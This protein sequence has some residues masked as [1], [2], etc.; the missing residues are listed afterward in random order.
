M[1]R[2]LVMHNLVLTIVV[3]R[4]HLVDL[5]GE[6]GGASHTRGIAHDSLLLRLTDGLKGD[7]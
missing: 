1:V 6:G 2:Y 3:L 5:V 7:A 4:L